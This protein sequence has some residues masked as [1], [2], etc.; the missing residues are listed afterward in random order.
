MCN[1]HL[2]IETHYFLM[3]LP[4]FRKLDETKEMSGGEVGLGLW[5]VTVYSDSD[6]KWGRCGDDNSEDCAKSHVDGHW[7]LFWRKGGT[8]LLI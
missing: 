3:N 6:G 8:F 7:R 5:I 1:V 4:S 2:I